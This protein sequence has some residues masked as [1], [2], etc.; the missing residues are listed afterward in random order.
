M[1]RKRTDK[2]QKDLPTRWRFLNGAFYYR[3]PPGQEVNWDGKITFRLGKT[4][5]EALEVFNLRVHAQ[6]DDASINFVISSYERHV[7]PQLAISTAK[8]YSLKIK[9]IRKKIGNNSVVKFQPSHAEK[10]RLIIHREIQQRNKTR[11]N[12]VTGF[13]TTREYMKVLKNIFE[14]AKKLA[15]IESNP[16]QHFKM[17]DEDRINNTKNKKK[18]P[19]FKPSYQHIVNSCLPFAQVS[20]EPNNWLQLYIKL[21]MATGLRQTDMLRLTSKNITEDGLFVEGHKLIN[22]D[23]D[24]PI[25]FAWENDL[26]FK[27]LVFD[28][29][30]LWK[31][32][33]MFFPKHSYFD[34]H[35]N[36]TEKPHA[37]VSAWQDFRQR[38]IVNGIEPFAERYIRNMVGQMSDSDEDAQNRLGHKSVKTTV[39]H[40]RK[41]VVDTT[42][43]KLLKH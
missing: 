5:Q 28:I 17:P 22:D 18:N 15:L 43:L 11:K 26:G 37:F 6:N 14:H 41:V 4:F 38:L 20:K 40:Y 24:R 29:S 36:Q 34:R 39:Q 19:P 9:T 30:N 2:T 7:L 21:K 31:H 13:K 12:P 16:L 3:V 25:L 33:E 23:N 8:A 32:S 10:F 35:G 1:G 27:S 42:P